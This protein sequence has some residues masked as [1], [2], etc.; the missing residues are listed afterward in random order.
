[1]LKKQKTYEKLWVVFEHGKKVFLF[2]FFQVLMFLL[3]VFCVFGKVA[4]VLKMLVF[5]SQFFWLLGVAYSCL[6]G[7]GRFRCFCVSCFCFLLFR[8]CFRLFCSVFVL[9]LDC[10]GVCSCFCFFPLFLVLFLFV[11]VC[12]ALFVLECFCIFFFLLLSLFGLL[13]FCSLCF[14]EWSR[15][16]SCFV[17]FWLVLLVFVFVSLCLFPSVS[18]ENHCVPAILVF[19]YKKKWI[20][21]SHFSF[22]FLLFVLFCLLSVSS[23]SFVLCLCFFLTLNH[24]II[25]LGFASSFLVVFLFLLLWYFVIFWILATYQKT[26]LKKLEIPK[27]P[28]MKNAEKKNW[29]FH[30]SS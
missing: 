22:W 4:K 9:L 2:V 19:F 20:S 15:C 1:M 17:I 23:C 8:F 24:N 11:L 6:F 5:F 25:F 26:S 27:T 29:R 14:L 3:F 30:K 13:L 12:C 18:H 7:F 16:C 28:K 21:V 10:F